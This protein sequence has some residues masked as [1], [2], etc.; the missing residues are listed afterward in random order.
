MPSVNATTSKIPSEAFSKQPPSLSPSHRLHIHRR[1]VSD[2]SAFNRYV[3]EFWILLRNFI[4]TNFSQRSTNFDL[5]FFTE[6]ISLRIHQIHRPKWHLRAAKVSNKIL[7][8]RARRKIRISFQRNR[9][10][11]RYG[12]YYSL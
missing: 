8:S 12:T 9:S 10:Q 7:R 2:T 3:M 4:E 11:S 5:F 1:I 6:L